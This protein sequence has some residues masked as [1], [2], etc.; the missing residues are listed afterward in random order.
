MTEDE[1]KTKWCPFSRA[2]IFVQGDGDVAISLVGQGSNRM[3][4][5]HPEINSKVQ[6]L[7]EHEGVTRCLGCKCMAWLAFHPDGRGRCGL[8]AS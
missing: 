1:A 6:M 3:V 8:V 5:D 2:A 4:I 7:I